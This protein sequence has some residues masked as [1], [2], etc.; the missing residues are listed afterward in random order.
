MSCS[1]VA[2]LLDQAGLADARLACQ[3]S[4]AGCALD[5]LVEQL[6]EGL[7]LPLSPKEAVR[8]RRRAHYRTTVPF[9]VAAVDGCRR[10]LFCAY[11]LLAYLKVGCPDSSRRS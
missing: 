7:E 11:E 4:T 10:C 2:R 8:G 3:E 9:L 6:G 1:P 5:S